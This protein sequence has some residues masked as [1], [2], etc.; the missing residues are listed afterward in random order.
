MLVVRDEEIA[1][2]LTALEPRCVR[3]FT[4]L[5]PLVPERDIGSETIDDGEFR[6][7]D[8]EKQ[9][10]R[11]RRMKARTRT[12]G[13]WSC[14]RGHARYAAPACASSEFDGRIRF[15]TKHPNAVAS[16]APTAI[17]SSSSPCFVACHAR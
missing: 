13:R 15:V 11:H 12:F 1:P 7:P 6:P 4:L 14:H 5:G 2:E 3:Q 9:G 17:H 10:D 16:V 8:Q